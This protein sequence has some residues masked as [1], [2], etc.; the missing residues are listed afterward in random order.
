MDAE[1]EIKARLVQIISLFEKEEEPLTEKIISSEYNAAVR[2]LQQA[3]QL[4]NEQLLKNILSNAIQNFNKA[5]DFEKNHRRLMS[6]WGLVMC[7]DYLGEK[8]AVQQI[9]AEVKKEEIHIPLLE[10]YGPAI[11]RVSAYGGYFVSSLMT[12]KNNFAGPVVKV[13]EQ[14]VKEQQQKLAHKIHSFNELK[15]KIINDFNTENK[16]IIEKDNS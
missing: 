10:K 9:V 12:R 14:S 16:T 8:E 2:Q 15:K 5:I 1:K 7:Y 13:T 4:K 3:K 6:F 11:T